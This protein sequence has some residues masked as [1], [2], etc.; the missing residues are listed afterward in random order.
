MVVMAG[1]FQK[2]KQRDQVLNSN[3]SLVL[4]KDIRKLNAVDLAEESRVITVSRRWS[5]WGHRG[6]RDKRLARGDRHRE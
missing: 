6:H 3:Q 2:C 4:R 1:K 5:L